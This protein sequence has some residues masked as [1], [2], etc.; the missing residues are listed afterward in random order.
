[1]QAAN[2][3]K[4]ADPIAWANA[5]VVVDQPDRCQLPWLVIAGCDGDVSTSS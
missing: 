3:Q 5:Q 2:I 4:N 1:M